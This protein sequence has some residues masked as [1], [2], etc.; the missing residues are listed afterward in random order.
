M[1]VIKESYPSKSDPSKYE[2]L[3]YRFVMKSS[4]GKE[5]SV[6]TYGARIETLYVPDS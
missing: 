6:I 3:S 4:D 5:V 2:D 1:S